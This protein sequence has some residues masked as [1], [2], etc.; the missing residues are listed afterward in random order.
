MKLAISNIAWPADRETEIATLMGELGVRAVELAPTKTWPKPLEAADGAV[1]TYRKWWESRGIAIVAIQSVLFGRPDL[2]LFGPETKRRETS[3]YLKGMIALAGKLGARI[4][5]FGSPKNRQR[6][7]LS[8]AEADAIA[9][10]FFRELGEYAA[11]RSVC[12]CIE[13]NAPQYACDFVVTSTE[14]RALVEAVGSEGFGLHLDLACMQLAGEIA[15][16]EALRHAAVTRHFHVSAPE[17]GRVEAKA[18]AEAKA[19]ASAYDERGKAPYFSIEMRAQAT[20]DE[21]LAAVR[22]ALELLTDPPKPAA[23]A[24]GSSRR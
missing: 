4:V 24:A 15:R 20:P 22:S 21:S 12:F 19:I 13:A 14:A 23:R 8:K 16:D 6:G 2:V 9:I 17:L 11:A 10:P 18:A 1:A 5:V 3:D 7:P